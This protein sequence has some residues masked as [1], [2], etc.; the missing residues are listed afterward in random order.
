MLEFI[1]TFLSTVLGF[2]P[3]APTPQKMEVEG[4]SYNREL[5]TNVLDIEFHSNSVSLNLPLSQMK[6]KL[7]G[8]VSSPFS[9]NKL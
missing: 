9:L 3:L 7:T 6:R 5:D 2:G 8:E 1:F 4:S